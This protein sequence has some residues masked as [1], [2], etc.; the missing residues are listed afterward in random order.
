VEDGSLTGDGPG[1]SAEH[2]LN[3]LRNM[4]E[5]AGYMIEQGQYEEACQQLMDVYRRVDGQ[6][7]PP[8]FVTGE[9]ASQL[10]ELILDLMADLG[11]Q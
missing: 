11:C 9:A 2:R 5:S 10:A 8:D 6:P 3:A 1:N 4:I 7:R